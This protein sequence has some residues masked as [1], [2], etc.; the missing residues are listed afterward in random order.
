VSILSDKVGLIRCFYCE[1][2]ITDREKARMLGGWIECHDCHEYR[3]G[4]T[5]ENR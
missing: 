5:E 2:V 1:A 3:L 4:I